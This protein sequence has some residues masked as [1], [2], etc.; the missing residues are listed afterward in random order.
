MNTKHYTNTNVP[1]SGWQ[2]LGELELLVGARGGDTLYTWLVG[3]LDPLNLSTDF[4]YRVLESVQASAARA[5]QPNPT[6]IFEHINLSF[7]APREHI[8]KGKT[9]GFFHIER[10][11]KRADEFD[12]YDHS[13][14]FYLYVE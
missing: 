11:E 3:I 1:D 14:D 8:S 4:L 2:L 10:I 7:F 9:W 12:A 5:L 6:I 13:I